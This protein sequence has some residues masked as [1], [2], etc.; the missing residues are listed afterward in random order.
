MRPGQAVSLEASV[1][2]LFIG[3]R[4]RGVLSSSSPSSTGTSTTDGFLIERRPRGRRASGGLSSAGLSAGGDRAG[5]RS[6][7]AGHAVIRDLPLVG[8]LLHESLCKVN[9]S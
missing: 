1:E 8:H 3:N 4:F 6:S 5:R 9:A 7:S 2:M